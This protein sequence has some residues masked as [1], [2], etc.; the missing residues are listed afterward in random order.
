MGNMNESL[1]ESSKEET[2]SNERAASGA[3]AAGTS[4]QVA[5]GEYDEAGVDLS[6]L[7]YMLELSPLERLT[8]MEQHAR[9]TQVLY[10]YGRRHR[11]AQAGTDR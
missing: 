11:E 10:E 3:V 2:K 8:R 9:D 5:P 7:R 6:L 1:A 4:V